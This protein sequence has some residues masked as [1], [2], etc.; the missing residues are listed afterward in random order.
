M[1]GNSPEVLARHQHQEHQAAADALPGARNSMP[2]WPLGETMIRLL[3]IIAVRALFL[4]LGIR[5]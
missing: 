1:F 3:H 2:A 5:V 4:L